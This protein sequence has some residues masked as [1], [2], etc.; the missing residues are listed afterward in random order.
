MNLN[1]SYHSDIVDWEMSFYICPFG[2]D[3]CSEFMECAK[4]RA[5]C[6]FENCGH[7]FRYYH[8]RH[9]LYDLLTYKNDVLVLC[10]LDPATFIKQ[11][12]RFSATN[13][14]GYCPSRLAFF[15]CS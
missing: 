7:I 5:L 6:L 10:L 3:N 8:L 1:E 15:D 4:G 11:E 13:Q 9:S 2:F 12:S 14:D